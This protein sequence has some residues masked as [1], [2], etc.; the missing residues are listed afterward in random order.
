MKIAVLG[1][2]AMGCLYGARLKQAGE[3][4]TLIDV[5]QAHMDAVNQKG[6]L[7]KYEEGETCVQIPACR[8][9]EYQETADLVIVFTKSTFSE[10]AVASLEHAIGE[11]TYML[12]LQNGL[13]HEK[14]MGRYVRPDH[15]IIGTTNFPS[16]FL[17]NGVIAV[18]G[19]GVTRMMTVT[20]TVDDRVEE[21]ACA[22]EKAGLNPELTKDVFQAVWEK[23]AFNAAMNSLTAVTHLPQGYL[24]QTEEG[25]EL[26]HQIVDEVLSV[27][28]AKGI[29]TERAHVHETVTNLF[30]DHFEHCPSMFQDVLKKRVTEIEAINGAVVREAGELGLHVPATR[31]MY[32]LVSIC[33]QTYPYRKDTI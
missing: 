1:A 18:H 28:E 8:A 3:N 16:D 32:Q 17:D 13:G 5:N 12:S 31:V 27:A 22:F 10:Q 24:G 23:V 7:V 11:E 19:A 4:V 2:G 30:R 29:Q 33:Q 15:I 14:I 9:E 20:R 6:L 25:S 26:A 21:I